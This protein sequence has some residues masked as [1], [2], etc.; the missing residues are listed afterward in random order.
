MCDIFLILASCLLFV[1]SDPAH[2][3]KFDVVAGKN[4]AA[5]RHT[6]PELDMKGNPTISYRYVHAKKGRE[7]S[8][9]KNT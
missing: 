8:R 4:E 5:G 2:S 1:L 3:W 9:W 6:S 7:K